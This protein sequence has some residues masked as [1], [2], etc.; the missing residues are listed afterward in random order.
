MVMRLQRQ[1]YRAVCA[2]F[3]VKLAVEL[4]TPASPQR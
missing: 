4:C 3:R 2:Q 1:R